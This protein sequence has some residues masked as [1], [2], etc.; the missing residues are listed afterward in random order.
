MPGSP[1]A[2]ASLIS[3][4]TATSETPTT[5]QISHGSY[6]DRADV[7][8]GGVGDVTVEAL[9]SLKVWEAV[10]RAR[11]PLYGVHRRPGAA[12]LELDPSVR[13]LRDGDSSGSE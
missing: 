11:D 6:A 3:R 5:A 10:E 9:G 12:D 1:E 2:I 4:P 8:P 7:W 13:L